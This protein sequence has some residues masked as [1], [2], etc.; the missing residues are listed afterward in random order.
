M[1]DILAKAHELAKT[2]EESA[3]LAA[4]REKEAAVQ[5]D[6][7]AKRIMDGLRSSQ[8]EYYNLQMSGEEPSA[9]LMAKIQSLQSE[10]EENSLVMDYME[11]QETLGKILQQVNVIISQ[12]L[13]GGQGCSG[14][15]CSSCSGC[16]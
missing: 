8:M 6:A 13:N 9:D 5:G 7:E 16:E 10:M 12:V 3:E 2:M 1:A 4:V 11:A 15:D 14:S